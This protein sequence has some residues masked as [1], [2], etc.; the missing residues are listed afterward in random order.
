M[1]PPILQNNGAQQLANETTVYIVLEDVNDEIPLFI[2]HEKETVLEGLPVNTK[3][4]QVQ[5]I[6]KDGTYPNNKV[7]LRLKAVGTVA[8]LSRQAI[9]GVAC[10]LLTC[11]VLPFPT[12]YCEPLHQNW[13]LGLNIL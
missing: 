8:G 7:S 10:R 2:E 1:E 11:L 6:D 5:S 9:S 3:V 13:A 12:C 4:T